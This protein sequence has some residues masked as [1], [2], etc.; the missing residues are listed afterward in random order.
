MEAM[1]RPMMWEDFPSDFRMGFKLMRT[2][3][4][5]W[6][7]IRV[8]NM[9]VSKILPQAIVR[10]LSAE[11]EDYYAAP[12]KTIQSRKPVRQ[13][14]RE[15]PIEGKPVDVYE[16]ILNYSQKLQESE[17]PKLLFFATPGGIIDDKRVEW[18]KRNLKNLK[19]VDIGK[20]IHFVQ[21]DNPYLIGEE[22]AKWYLN[23]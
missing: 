8:M 9:F 2:S 16:L 11:E 3:G 20:G 13:W 22:L 12:Y 7:M 4:V 1:M 10:K 15:I 5:G 17:L 6:F 18:C 14:P 23:L 19:V 21:E